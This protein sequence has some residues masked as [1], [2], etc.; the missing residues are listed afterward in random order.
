MSI[1][2]KER[3][4]DSMAQCFVVKVLKGAEPGTIKGTAVK[5]GVD[6]PRGYG[7]F[8]N[9]EKGSFADQVADPSR[10]KVLWQHDEDQPI[11]RINELRDVADRMDF[12]GRISTSDK[13]PQAETALELLRDEILDE[14]SVGFDI[15]KFDRQIDEE[16]DRVTYIVKKARLREISVVTF[17]ALGEDAVVQ[18]VA[19]ENG[20]QDAARTLHA[21]LLRA[22]LSRLTA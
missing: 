18:Q 3:R 7:L 4:L 12:G 8:L 15:L 2:L 20:G 6:V 16:Q 5:Y 17:G 21:R 9:V 13:V 14:V 22:E 19:N 10:V 1:A 11:G